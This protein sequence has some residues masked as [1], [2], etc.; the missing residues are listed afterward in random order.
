[1]KKA[2]IQR[3]KRIL[4]VLLAEMQDHRPPR[5]EIAVQHASDDIDR[6]QQAAERDLAIRRMEST[7]NRMQD[8]S[9]A[10]ERIE[11][12]TYGTC[13]RC[14]GDI[15]PARLRAV[16]WA[17]YCIRCQDFADRTHKTPAGERPELSPQTRLVA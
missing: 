15:G 13:L 2:E 10:L 1:M 9:L 4:E 14:E 12:G 16:P 6:I 3:F 7:F 17:G 5:D 8:I 11:D